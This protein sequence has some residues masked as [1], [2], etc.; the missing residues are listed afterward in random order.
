MSLFTQNKNQHP[1]VVCC[2]VRNGT[3]TAHDLYLIGVRT[4]VPNGNEVVH[5][6][7]TL[8]CPA[9]SCISH[10]TLSVR[11]VQLLGPF[12]ADLLSATDMFDSVPL[13]SQRFTEN[14]FLLFQSSFCCR[15]PQYSHRLVELLGIHGLTHHLVDVLRCN[16]NGG[17]LHSVHVSRAQNRMCQELLC[18]RPATQ[19][20]PRVVD[21]VSARVLKLRDDVPDNSL[22]CSPH[23]TLPMR[24]SLH[25]PP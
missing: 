18:L 25:M 1:T 9:E 20:E 2:R 4:D 11:L 16:R 8:S 3:V 7:S 14:A 17:T 15:Q 22:A 21:A 10:Y 19:L 23:V 24:T 13:V 12:L 5:L 6:R